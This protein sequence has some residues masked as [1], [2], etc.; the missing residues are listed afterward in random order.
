MNNWCI[1]WFSHTFLLGILILKRLTARRLYKSCGVKGLIVVFSVV[2]V[3]CGK[4]S[5]VCWMVISGFSPLAVTVYFILAI[6]SGRNTS[7]EPWNVQRWR[8]YFGPRGLPT[9][10]FFQVISC[11]NMSLFVDGT[12]RHRFIFK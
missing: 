12:F 2:D 7:F 9:V 3:L 8:S 11:L 1:C 5:G 6:A 4:V 10:C